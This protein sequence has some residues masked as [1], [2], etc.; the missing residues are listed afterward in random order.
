VLSQAQ[1]SPQT[2]N[3]ATL[4]ADGA[5]FR[6][7]APAAD[8][9]YLHGIFGGQ[10][11]DE[12]TDDRLLQKDARGYWTGY[13]DGARDGDRYRFWVQGAGSSGNKRD[14][15]AR[16]LEPDGFPN[17]FC[18][19]RARS[20][21]WHDQD[22][23]TPDFSDMIVYQLHIGTFAIAK[24]GVPSNFLDVALKI[25][26]LAEL[27]INV[28]QPLP[29]DEQEAN[30]NMGY[31]GADLFS[32]DF[33]YVAVENLPFYLER[34]NALYA[35]KS[36][37]PIRLTDI[38]SAPGQLKAL[39]DLCHL[40]GI[41]VIFD[42]VYNH[43][44]GFSIDGKFDDN[45]LYYLDRRQDRGNNNDSLYFTDQDRGT[46]GL[47]F[48][49]WNDE[50]SKFLIDNARYY[51]EEFHA[52]G[53]RYD[54]ISTLISTNQGGGWQFCRALTSN[55]RGYSNRILQNAEF[56][57]GRFPDI[58]ASPLPVVAP[59][60][61]GGMGF[62][63]V[64]HDYLRRM[65]RDAVGAASGGASATVPV[66]AIAAA[67]Y[68][69]GFDHPWRAVTC[70]EN[71]DLVLAGRDPRLPTLADSSNHRSWYARSRSRV[72]S[73][74]LLTA[75]GIPQIFMGQEFLEDKPWDVDPRGPNLLS[76][77]GLDAPQDSS[78]RDHLQFT[79]DLIRLR[80]DLPALRSDNVRAFYQSDSDRVIAY[81]RWREGT[82]DDVIVV[83]SFA[84]TTWSSYEI[85]FPS[86]GLW[87]ERFNS[88]AYDHFVNPQVAG[89][90]GA[91]IAEGRGLHGFV[92]SAPIVIPANGVVV[93]VKG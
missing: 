18:I 36:R 32:P 12:L 14:P 59:A 11:F 24:P 66:S 93:F 85:G 23:V 50:V 53:F 83:A 46:G 89:N 26:Y 84:E 49:L 79:K 57:A 22:F 90:G 92:A 10:V 68:P 30:P 13:Q 62:D 75:P 86:P 2:P 64:Q 5:T 52:D 41:A 67:L 37:S 51:L 15:Y 43:A 73:A 70:A 7:W 3:G 35:A 47:A 72:A 76:W 44:G 20:F 40:H 81:H 78:M 9:V 1:I 69:P 33:P 77:D 91:V 6:V 80:R 63:V 54:E 4:G 25:P 31:A 16:E 21:P 34:L 28:L 56:W 38:Q 45:C 61:A 60:D 87:K 74:I 65:L 42:V 48:A 39:V 8:A 88:D 55:L 82:G 58:P 17:C 27:G 19:L 29:V 71:H